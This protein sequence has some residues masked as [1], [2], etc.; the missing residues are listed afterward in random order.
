MPELRPN[1]KNDKDA[2]YRKAKKA[3][4]ATGE[5]TSLWHVGYACREKFIEDHKFNDW[6][7]PRCSAKDFD[8]YEIY[9][10]WLDRILHINRDSNST[11]VLPEKVSA[12]EATWKTPA[13]AEFFVD[14]ETVN[15][16]DDDFSMMPKKNGNTRIFMIG[17]GHIENGEWKFE[18]FIADDLTDECELKAITDW[19]NHMKAVEKRLSPNKQDATQQTLTPSLFDEPSQSS[20]EATQQPSNSPIVFHWSPAEKSTF[21]TQYESAKERHPGKLPTVNFYDFL[22]NVIKPKGREDCVVV[23]GAFAF[24]LKAIGKALHKH[25]LIETN[26]A[27]GPTD[28]LGAMTGAW[29]CYDQAK[30]QG[31]PILEIT[32]SSG[33]E[34]F[35]EIRDY[36]EVDCKVMYETINYLRKNH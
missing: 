24:G 26:W 16:M 22:A 10:P 23:K 19:A 29:W 1:M 8:I 27:D 32:T 30:S 13:P 18:C 20:S 5:L 31:K 12:G 15:D 25:G 35:R 33:R 28:G 7:D 14:F 36:N 21:L 11:L 34:L 3:I 9:K 2:P 4:A 6:R 17:C